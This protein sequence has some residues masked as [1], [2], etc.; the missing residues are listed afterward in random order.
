M[1]N[2]KYTGTVCNRFMSTNGIML[3]QVCKWLVPD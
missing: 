1:V 2:R 3:V